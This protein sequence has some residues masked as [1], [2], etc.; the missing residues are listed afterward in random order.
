MTKQLDLRKNIY[1]VAQLSL[2]KN[3]ICLRIAQAFFT[4]YI[5]IYQINFI[6]M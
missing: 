4:N 2:E 3:C 6:D 5:I 1:S